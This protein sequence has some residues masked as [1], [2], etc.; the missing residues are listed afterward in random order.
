MC[1]VNMLC[2][3]LKAICKNNIVVFK[4]VRTIQINR[5][6]ELINFFNVRS[7]EIKP[8]NRSVLGGASITG[9]TSNCDSRILAI[10]RINDYRSGFLLQV[11][12]V[13]RN[14]K[15][16]VVYT[17][18]KN[19][20][21]RSHLISGR[22]CGNWITIHINL[23][24]GVIKT[25]EVVDTGAGG[26]F[27]DGCGKHC[28]IGSDRIA[29]D[30]GNIGCAGIH[31]QIINY[32]HITVTN[33][34]TV[35]KGN[36]INKEGNFLIEFVVRMNDKLNER[37]VHIFIAFARLNYVVHIT[38]EISRGNIHINISPSAFRD[39]SIRH[40]VVC[41]F[42]V[43]HHYL[44]MLSLPCGS[45]I[46]TAG[47]KNTGTDIYG[48]FRYIHPHTDTA[49]GISVGYITQKLIVI[50]NIK[51]DQMRISPSTT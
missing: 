51:I 40:S 49:S 27:L 50:E 5:C 34:R 46:R 2:S 26:I 41:N 9:T 14:F 42:P 43:V 45:A 39:T 36:I 12:C 8:V 33:N 32:R 24:R 7:S 35:I 13:I 19:Y 47:P 20:F 17:I 30:C 29:V 48:V 44:A 31:L 16:N 22:I 21:N 37:G 4:I 15:C 38:G 25:C 28:I 11:T 3:S 23:S 1:F 10:S 6:G 18:G